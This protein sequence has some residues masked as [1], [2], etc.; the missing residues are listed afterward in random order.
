MF[1]CTACGQDYL[2][3]FA[4]GPWDKRVATL[5]HVNDEV[6]SSYIVETKETESLEPNDNYLEFIKLQHA[7]QSLQNRKV[8][9]DWELPIYDDVEAAEKVEVAQEA[10]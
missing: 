7:S 4:I 1:E 10:E 9:D 5:E 8:K 6:V 3:P 2:N